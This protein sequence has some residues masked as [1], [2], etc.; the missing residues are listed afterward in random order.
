DG[1]SEPAGTYTA[2][3]LAGFDSGINFSSLNG[4]TLTIGAAVPEPATVLGGVL[5]VGTLGWNQ[6]R[7]L[8]AVV[9]G[10]PAGLAA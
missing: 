2:A 10:R 6:R 8:Q 9:A 7:R 5:L 4:E 1:T 3:Q